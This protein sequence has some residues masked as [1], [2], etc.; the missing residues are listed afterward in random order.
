[1]YGDMVT[2]VKYGSLYLK[3]EDRNEYDKYAAAI[4]IGGETGEHIPKNF[5]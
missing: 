3:C 2:E 1:M 5:G 4:M